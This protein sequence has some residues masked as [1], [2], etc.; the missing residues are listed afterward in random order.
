[1][2]LGWVYVDYLFMHFFTLFH[3]EVP[4]FEQSIANVSEPKMNIL[5]QYEP[6]IEPI[7]EVS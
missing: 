5:S 6:I 7:F 3:I 4:N 1:M 2:K